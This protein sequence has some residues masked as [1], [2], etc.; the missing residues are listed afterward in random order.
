MTTTGPV[1]SWGWQGRQGLRPAHGIG[2][3]RV[4]PLRAQPRGGL[5]VL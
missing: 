4:F 2:G 1:P 3:R 5:G